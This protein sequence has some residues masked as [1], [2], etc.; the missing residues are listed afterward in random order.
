MSSKKR[1]LLIA[2]L[3]ISS[4]LLLC[5]Y[6]YR[7]SLSS[8]IGRDPIWVS[9]ATVD[10]GYVLSPQGS[11]KLR[12]TFHD[13]GAVHSGNFWTWVTVNDWLRGRTVVAQGYS[14]Y[15]VRYGREPFPIEWVDE[16]NFWIGF[17]EKRGDTIQKV[18][19]R[20]E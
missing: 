9:I 12:I 4:F 19:T 17:S 10:G 13:A 14:T 2:G 18:L 7:Q 8:V 5:W 15:G 1:K 3:I 16:R 6:L 11:V 20:M